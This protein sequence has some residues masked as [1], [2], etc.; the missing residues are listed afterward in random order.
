MEVDCTQAHPHWIWKLVLGDQ[1]NVV[2][3]DFL[4]KDSIR[5]YNKVTVE[6]RVFKNLQLF[7]Q[8]KGGQ[9]DLF[10]RLNVSILHYGPHIMS[11]YIVLCLKCIRMVSNPRKTFEI[12][13]FHILGNF[14]SMC[15][16]DP[17][18]MFAYIVVK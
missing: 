14:I 12:Q 15:L 11:H 4:G 7:T 8:N 17:L 2:E 18:K 5:Y 9:D 13:D 10:D 1:E 16:Y 6:K 3:F